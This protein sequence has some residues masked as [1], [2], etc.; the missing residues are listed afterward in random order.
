MSHLLSD[1]PVTNYMVLSLIWDQSQ[2]SS[3]IRLEMASMNA[4]VGQSANVQIA[5]FPWFWP[6]MSLL[7]GVKKI[8]LATSNQK[9]NKTVM[10]VV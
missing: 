10:Y 4:W 2:L 7:L 1:L 9:D 6:Q 8:A 5:N 3:L